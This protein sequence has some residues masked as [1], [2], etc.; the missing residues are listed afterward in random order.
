MKLAKRAFAV[1]FATAS[2][3]AAVPL[4]CRQVLGIQE[5][6][7]DLL[8]CDLYCDT[9]AAGCTGSKL[10]YVSH[11][12]CIGLCNNLPVGHTADTGGNTLG[13]RLNLANKIASTGE[14]D[15]AAA[16]PGGGAICGPDCDSFCGV[17]LKVC[18]SDFA[19]SD[20]CH[21]ACEKLPTD[22][23]PYAVVPETTPDTYTIQCR[24]FHVTAATL[25][26][27]EHCPHVIGVEYCRPDSPPCTSG[28]AGNGG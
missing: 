4:G 11:E 20:D 8:T 18:P 17:A 23:A 27:T 6:G 26:P 16:G 3:G 22:C 19:S 15:C 13:C 10:Q 5:V 1:F 14:G 9:I 12:A 21:T 28:D 24:L 7:S 2:V 25:D